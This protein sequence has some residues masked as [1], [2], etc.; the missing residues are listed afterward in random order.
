[1]KRAES[2]H[3]A[4]V[5]KITIFGG[6]SDDREDPAGRGHSDACWP[7]LPLRRSGRPSAIRRLLPPAGARR[8][9]EWGDP[10]LRGIYPLDQV[11]R[12][13]MQRR[14]QYGNR[15]LMTT[16]NTPRRSGRGRG[17]GRRRP[18]GRQQPARRGNWF[19]YGTALRQTALIVEPA[20][21]GRIPEL[22]AEGKR[23]QAVDESSWNG[24]VFEGL[25][26]SIRSTAA[27]PAACR[28][29]CCRS[30]TTTA[31]ASSSRRARS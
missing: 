28:R 31:S 11:G 22:T 8:R 13:P 1:M 25:R 12:T 14:P 6:S 5:R 20:E 27:S 23:R 7:P 18:R 19:E 16:R 21:N 30:R 24:Q 9:T 4:I 2:M 26:T 29:R 3:N 15:L 17:R 10:D